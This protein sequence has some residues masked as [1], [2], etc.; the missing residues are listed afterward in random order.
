V[1]DLHLARQ[2]T[3]EFRGICCVITDLLERQK[4]ALLTR[5]IDALEQVL[6]VLESQFRHA[7]EIDR[8]RIEAIHRIEPHLGSKPVEEA[9]LAL[10]SIAQRRDDLQLAESF[11]EMAQ[12]FSDVI[13]RMR[14]IEH[15]NRFLVRREATWQKRFWTLIQSTLSYQRDGTV[16]SPKTGV[17]NRKV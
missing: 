2:F 14:A 13:H 15:V 10:A 12:G 1:N 6:E 7:Q 8:R 4:E 17:L 9:T 11:R 5:N 16:V 3:H